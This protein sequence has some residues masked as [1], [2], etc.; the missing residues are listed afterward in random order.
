MKKLQLYQSRGKTSR[1]IWA[2]I[3]IDG[4]LVLSCKD[5][6]QAPRKLLSNYEFFVRVPVTS[7]DAVYQALVDKLSIDNPK[8]VEKLKSVKSQDDKLIEMISIMYRGKSD[9]VDDF[10]RF[11][12]K[13]GIPTKFF[14]YS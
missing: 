13:K 14:S 9:A 4:D 11:M 3:A 2:E 12:Q 8:A 7:K 1:S 5:V 10:Q 6:G